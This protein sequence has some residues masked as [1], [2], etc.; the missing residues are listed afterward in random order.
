MVRARL[1]RCV[2]TIVGASFM[3]A[4]GGLL[5]RG[6]E[7]ERLSIGFLLVGFPLS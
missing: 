1:A 4:P 7:Q 5:L 2:R 3:R 6:D